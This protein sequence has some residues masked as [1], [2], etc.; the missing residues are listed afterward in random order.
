MP[1]R[2]AAFRW[3][4]IFALGVCGAILADDLRAHPVYCGFGGGCDEVLSSPYGHP[5]GVPLSLIG[6]VAFSGLLALTTM[7][8]GRARAL[9]LPAALLA[10]A[11]GATLILVQLAVLRRI[12][13]LC[14]LVDLCAV[15]LAGIGNGLRGPGV[16]RATWRKQ[17][18]WLSVA[19]LTFLA[20]L[21][22]AWLRPARPVPE[23]VQA[24]WL[25][26]KITIV[27]I[28]DFDGPHCRVAD[29][30]LSNVLANHRQ[31]VHFVRF[32]AA[33]PAH[34]NSRPAAR[35]DTPRYTR[36]RS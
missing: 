7:A 33:Q 32:A 14:F 8:D 25:G 10:G 2:L 24:H 21:G 35:A 18:V 36:G 22:L 23:E 27:E 15:A 16:P 31:R 12:C 3:I 26:G 9:M 19:A 1:W 11:I 29:S 13:A 30:V 34:V 20:P 6:A 28:T 4:T 17:C 5:F